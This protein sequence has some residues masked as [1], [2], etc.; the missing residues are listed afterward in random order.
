MGSTVDGNVVEIGKSL[1]PKPESNYRIPIVQPL[2][3]HFADLR[4]LTFVQLQYV[5]IQFPGC[6]IAW[7]GLV[8]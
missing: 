5:L 7:Y 6:L 3:N 2:T 4:Q 8:S 1:P